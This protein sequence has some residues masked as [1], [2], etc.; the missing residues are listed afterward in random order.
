MG[1]R[2]Y[3]E[4]ERLTEEQ[5]ALA[6]ELYPDAIRMMHHQFRGFARR[7][8]EE[9]EACAAVACCH[10]AA[11][12]RP[13]GGA[14]IKSLLFKY[15][16]GFCM[17]YLNRHA[18]R[19]WT[20]MKTGTIGPPERKAKKGDGGPWLDPVGKAAPERD[21]T[22]DPYLKFLDARQ[23]RVLEM[24]FALGLTMDEAGAVLGVTKE[25]VRQL[26]ARAL[27]KLRAVIGRTPNVG[28]KEIAV[29]EW[30]GV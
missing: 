25:R 10:V 20:R 18:K 12:W 4:D 2:K 8:R 29:F 3:P 30:T 1:R 14:A 6:A 19:H 13:D 21:D 11:R 28:G 27:A 15:V 26:E 16:R 17:S 9:F 7:F 22:L 5:R 24:R 23:R